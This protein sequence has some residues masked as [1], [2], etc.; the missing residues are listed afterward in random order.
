VDNEIGI[1]AP[2]NIL[3]S[4]F[5]KN[6]AKMA[7][8]N[9]DTEL[10]ES[11][12]GI[13]DTITKFIFTN[14]WN[15]NECLYV[16]CLVENKQRTR[17]FS[18]QSNYLALLADLG[19]NGR[20]ELILKHIN[21][22]KENRVRSDIS[23]FMVYAVKALFGIGR[24]TEALNMMAQRYNRIRRTGSE[25]LWEE[26]SNLMSIRKGTW[27][28][29]YRSAAQCGAAAQ[30][31]ILSSEVLGIKALQPH[32]KEFL[33][34]P[35]TGDLEWAKGTVAT[36]TGTIEVTWKKTDMDIILDVSVPIGTS[37]I[38]H[39]P[40]IA[41]YTLN[42]LPLPEFS[43]SSTKYSGAQLIELCPGIHRLAPS[44]N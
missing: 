38:V 14:F 24:S 20:Q 3:I 12:Q 42:G 19:K 44:Q 37:A 27:F 5:F 32:F 15:E 21:L 40:S 1:G 33:V 41:P 43:K 25:T 2:Q 17:V 35:Q 4:L 22:D 13:S 30:A 18:E 36:P 16:D 34:K 39:L 6:L 8:D 26:W 7:V 31:G 10:A 9:Q 11:F 29:R 23:F 28:A